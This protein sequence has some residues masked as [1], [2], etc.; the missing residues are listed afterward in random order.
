MLTRALPCPPQASLMWARMQ[1]MLSEEVTV[2]VKVDSANRGGLL[3]KYGPFDG[4]VPV[5]QFGQA[6]PGITYVTCA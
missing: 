4:F 1:Y 3:V 2:K 5:G 6:S